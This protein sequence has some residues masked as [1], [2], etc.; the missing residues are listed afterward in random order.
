MIELLLEVLRQAEQSAPAMQAAVAVHGARVMA[1]FDIQAADQLVERGI[2]LAQSLP[3][4]ERSPMLEEFPSVI[5]GTD[6]NRAVGLF[7][8]LEKGERG[9]DPDR[10]LFA[11]L[12]HGHVAEAVEHLSSSTFGAD[13]PYGALMNAMADCRDNRDA[14]RAMLRSAM[15]A[16]EKHE[17]GSNGFGDHTFI[18]VFNSYWIVLP[19]EEAKAFV[20]ALVQRMLV[21]QDEK[22]SSSFGGHRRE[23]RFTSMQQQKLFEVFG[24]LRHLDPSFAESLLTTRPELAEAVDIC[25]DGPFD[26]GRFIEPPVSTP[27]MENRLPAEAIEW[28]SLRFRW[29][30]V[31][32]WMKTNWENAFSNAMALLEV[33]TGPRNPNMHPHEVWPSTQEFRVLMYKAGRYEGRDAAPRIDRIPHPDVRLLA[34]I[35][36]IAGM[37]G[38]PQLGGSS[39]APRPIEDSPAMQIAKASQAF[40]KLNLAALPIRWEGKGLPRE[41]QIEF[42]AGNRDR[43]QW[44]SPLCRE[45]ALFRRDGQLDQSRGTLLDLTCQYDGNARLLSIEASGEDG[46]RRFLCT[47]DDNANLVRV[48]KTQEDKHQQ[49]VDSFPAAAHMDVFSSTFGGFRVDSAT[50]ITIDYNSHRQP[51]T[52]FYRRDGEPQYRMQRKWDANGRLLSE[53][54]QAYFPQA[55]FDVPSITLRYEYDSSGRCTAMRTDFGEGHAFES[56]FFYDDRDNMIEFNSSEHHQRFEYAYDSQG[57]WTERVTWNWDKAKS[58][59]VK[60][61]VERRRIEYFM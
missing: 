44:G 51:T 42:T 57:N 10:L 22:V 48:E 4:D 54:N 36:F 55:V 23:V 20:R 41:I 5:A 15:K 29:I 14:Q 61:S 1:K 27:R 60:A 24:S 52:L 31:A 35:E 12:A 30:P 18:Q 39:R 25:P 3:P 8:S 58:E 53:T 2:S 46:P 33:D 38:L 34:K 49:S 56:T 43:S 13:F 37:V 32:E 21:E 26:L 11:M 45:T 19:T 6:P 50:G 9:P 17:S 16:T 59:Y 40:T 7:V 28:D 47:Y